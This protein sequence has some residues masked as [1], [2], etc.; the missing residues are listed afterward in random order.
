MVAKKEKER[1]RLGEYRLT[2]GI[3]ERG[4]ESINLR[5]VSLRCNQE[6]MLR[7]RP[8][9]LLKLFLAVTVPIFLFQ[10]P[11]TGLSGPPWYSN[12]ELNHSRYFIFICAITCLSH[13]ISGI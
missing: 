12:R 5:P 11:I 1:V 9:R 2:L 7:L 13:E 3:C 4:S 6:T 10:I 8:L